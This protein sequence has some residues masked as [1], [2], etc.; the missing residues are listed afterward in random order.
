MK[1]SKGFTLIEIIIFIVVIGI[2][3]GT[4]LT[5]MEVILKSQHSAQENGVAVQVASRCLE[6]YWGQNQMNGYSS[7]TCPSTTL[8]GFCIAPTGFSVSVNVACT[9]LYSEPSANYKTITATVTGKG[10][11]TLS[12]L[13]ADDGT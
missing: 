12:L 7:V 5:W 8:P 3:A 1:K 10:S 4:I 2:A 6:W 13:L 9:T 11:S